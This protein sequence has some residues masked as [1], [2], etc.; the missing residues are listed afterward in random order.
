MVWAT[1]RRHR[2]VQGRYQDRTTGRSGA[3]GR[4]SLRRLPQAGL[5][6]CRIIAFRLRAP[7]MYWSMAELAFTVLYLMAC[8]VWCFAPVDGWEFPNNLTARTWANRTGKLATIQLPF[9]VLLVTKNSF[10]T[11]LTGIGHEKL[12]VVHRAVARC[13]LLLT[14]LHVVGM[15]FR[16]RGAILL[17]SF[18]WKW[19]GLVGAVCQTI[20]TLVSNRWIRRRFYEA[21]YA[22]HVL[23]IITFLVT[24]HIHVQPRDSDVYIWGVWGIWGFDRLCR[25]GK[26]IL[27][28]YILR[29]RT[30]IAQESPLNALVEHIGGAG[31]RIT[32][33]RRLP[34]GWR[35]GQHALVAFPSVG[36]QSHPITIANIYEPRE[37]NEADMVFIVRAENGISGTLLDRVLSTATGKCEV[38]A[39]IDGPYGVPPDIRPYST[40][41]FIAGGTGVAYTLPRLH[42]L[43][44]DLSAANACT[45]RVVFV[46]A[47][48]TEV[49]YGWVAAELQRALSEAPS[50]LSLV[51]DL[52]LTNA[53]A[54]GELGS[55]PSLGKNEE[56]EAEYDLE[57]GAAP[58][59]DAPGPS[60]AHSRSDS[61][62]EMK[63]K[64]PAVGEGASKE[65]P[66]AGVRRKYGRPNVYNIL[67]EEVAASCGPVSVD[68]SGPDGLVSAVRNALCAPFAGPVA[69]LRGAPTVLLN[70]EQFRL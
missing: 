31:I 59:K 21:F 2:A 7:F 12:N 16:P 3:S 22:S 10:I 39:M 23:F 25:F 49:E 4:L 30:S 66:R 63:E 52:Y 15:Y 44:R 34:W 69:N 14:W 36:L 18:G 67:E 54:K 68:V 6:I 62:E 65:L 53:G 42:Q 61:S 50:S 35:A 19:A 8:L 64:S 32:V 60:H 11:W 24:T 20:T 9:I 47:V 55:V 57:K 33:R 40:C 29:P 26:Y 27:L 17:L 37:N 46:W 1:Y 43:L 5:T 45:Q 70:V 13:I 38:P 28:N 58:G 41:V 51:L 56:G 48:R